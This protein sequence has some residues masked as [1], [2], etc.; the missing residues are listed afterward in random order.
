MQKFYINTLVCLGL[1]ITLSSCGGKSSNSNNPNNISATNANFNKSAAKSS[2]PACD[3]TDQSGCQIINYAVNSDVNNNTWLTINGVPISTNQGT[4]GFTNPDTFLNYVGSPMVTTSNTG[5][6]N[7]IMSDSKNVYFWNF[8]PQQ[9]PSNTYSGQNNWKQ[10]SLGDIVTNLALDNWYNSEQDNSNTLY[11]LSESDG[12]DQIMSSTDKNG[13]DLSSFSQIN[14][15]SEYA[16]TPIS[17]SRDPLA[18]YNNGTTTTLYTF[19]KWIGTGTPYPSLICITLPNSQSSTASAATCGGLPA[20]TIIT[21]ITISYA[22]IYVET[23]KG[24]LYRASVLKNQN[25]FTLQQI[26][27]TSNNGVFDLC[28]TDIASNNF[29]IPSNAMVSR[30]DSSTTVLPGSTVS[31]NGIYL[32]GGD[33]IY[34]IDPQGSDGFSIEEIAT[35][36]DTSATAIAVGETGLLFAALTKK[37]GENTQHFLETYDTN[38]TDP[39]WQYPGLNNTTAVQPTLPIEYQ[40]SDLTLPIS[41][42]GVSGDQV[43]ATVVDSSGDIY[44]YANSA[45]TPNFWSPVDGNF[46]FESSSPANNFKISPSLATDSIDMPFM[47]DG[48]NL[49]NLTIP[50]TGENNGIIGINQLTGPIFDM[51]GTDEYLYA[52]K[53]EI[54]SLNDNATTIYGSSN[55]YYNSYNDVYSGQGLKPEANLS[56]NND[57]GGALFMANVNGPAGADIQLVVTSDYPNQIYNPETKTRISIP[58]DTSDILY[59]STDDISQEL[60]ISTQNNIYMTSS[61]YTLAPTNNTWNFINLGPTESR[62]PLNGTTQLIPIQQSVDNTSSSLLSKGSSSRYQSTQATIDALVTCYQG[63]GCISRVDYAGKNMVAVINYLYTTK[64][65]T[66]NIM[67]KTLMITDSKGNDTLI[68]FVCDKNLVDGQ[69]VFASTAK[70]QAGQQFVSTW[71]PQDLSNLEILTLTFSPND[72]LYSQLKECGWPQASKATPASTAQPPVYI[73]I[74]YNHTI[75]MNRNRADL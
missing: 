50:P 26:K 17:T 22:Y 11:V 29:Y 73:D 32:C 35:P 3:S 74:P 67:M 24:L 65:D 12:N 40:N 34:S 64:S 49:W 4:G 70:L 33:K 20:N 30:P 69:R 59:I 52:G 8:Y 45:V 6:M 68:E 38:A 15:A 37:A 14:L 44:M 46:I 31:Y 57:G 42:I 5:G 58:G 9:T 43:I 18:I 60:Y 39:S 19:G 25:I 27:N 72:S 16:F 48:N 13:A 47:T 41:S 21:A 54:Y 53:S 23:N 2:A 10:V 1:A 61:P 63:N 71:V 28:A 36:K 51:S 75:K 56:P 7:Y 62:F 55:L 66:D